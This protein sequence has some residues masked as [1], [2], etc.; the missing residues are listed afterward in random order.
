[1]RRRDG[2]MHILNTTPDNG[3]VNDFMAEAFG[4]PQSNRLY[5]IG[6]ATHA[7]VDS[8]AHQ[9]FVGWYDDLNDTGL[10]PLPEIGHAEAGHK[11]DLVQYSWPDKRLTYR[12]KVVNNDRFLDAARRLFKQYCDY[13]DGLEIDC[14]NRP[15]PDALMA[16]LDL[17]VS[18][19][20]GTSEKQRRKQHVSAYVELAPWLDE[21]EERDWFDYAI[22]TE[23]RGLPDSHDGIISSLPTFFP[24]RYFWKSEKE[25]THWFQ[26]QR[27]V[28]AHERFGIE[29][30]TP[31]FKEMGVDL[32]RA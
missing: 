29:R 20:T 8:W 5:R 28:K 12:R 19:A 17:A 22:R 3:L 13:L 15:S 6:I 9:N 11:P 21:Y 32:S 10:N 18:C 31:L 25:T 7:Y 26:F 16:R 14:P 24:D 4:S 27:A 30:L 1:A 23:V 2:K